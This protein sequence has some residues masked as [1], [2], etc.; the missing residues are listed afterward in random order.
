M[1]SGSSPRTTTFSVP[2][3]RLGAQVRGLGTGGRGGVARSLDA[4]EPGQWLGSAV[5]CE[6]QIGSK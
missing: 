2:D 5:F 6:S 4:G 3:H 1:F